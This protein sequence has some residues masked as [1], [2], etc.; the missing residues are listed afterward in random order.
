[1]ELFTKTLFLCLALALANGAPAHPQ[2]ATVEEGDAALPD[3]CEGLEFDAITPDE[4]GTTFFF[5]GAHLWK[6][7]HGP[8]QLS[9]EFFKE[10]DDIHHVGHVDAAFRMHSTDNP[11]I[12]DHI[13][14]FLDDKVFSYYNQTLE[15][16]Y[17]KEIQEDFPGV[18]SHLD[19]A[20]ECPK[21]ECGADSV[22]FFKGHDVHVYDI[23]TK[24]VKTKTWSHLPACTSVLHWQEHYY[25][26]HGHN[27]T[28]FNP[29]SGEVSGTYPKDARNYFMKCPNF[30]HG[31][32]YKVPKC[33]EVKID[34][35]TTDDAGKTYFFAGPIY[36]RLDTRRDGLHSFP[37]TRM[38][39]EVTGGVDAVFSYTDKIYLIKGDQV[40][41][42]KVDAHSTLI[43]GYPKSL[44][45]ELGIEGQVDAAFVCPNQHIVH[46]IQGQRIRDVD[47]TTTPRLV[48]RDLLLPLS[49]IDGG[50][51]SSEGIDVFKGSQY[52]HYESAMTLVTSRLAPLPLNITSAM[53]GC[54]D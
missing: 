5:K 7:F 25:C 44:K 6:G 48:A 42:Y 15:D 24:T 43:E 53:M 23:T 3:R 18:P 29:V 22:L 45:E 35:I 20:V 38:W 40:Y 33:S 39:K 16:G 26:F 10:L 34:A 37:I 41:I 27:F 17:P 31:G 21:G 30:G 50:L 4:K 36:M 49:D 9:N 14:F 8:A 28:K 19:A 1:M 2:D 52:Y 54:Q 51:C 12:H 47:L 11:D 46:I 13:Y 32:D